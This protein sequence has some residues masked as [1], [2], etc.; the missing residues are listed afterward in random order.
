M[1]KKAINLEILTTYK[2]NKNCP[3]CLYGQEKDN[4]N[5]VSLGWLEETLNYIARSFDIKSICLS[6]GEISLLGDFYLE[7]LF[8]L[9]KLYT[10][11][12]RV[13]TNLKLLNKTILN[14]FDT[15]DVTLNFNSFDSEIDSSLENI[16][17]ISNSKILNIKSLDRSCEDNPTEIIDLLNSLKIKSWE[18][19]PYH[20]TQ[21]LPYKV[22]D[23]HKYENIVKQYLNLYKEMNFAFQNRQQLQNIYK[24]DNYNIQNFYITPNNKIAIQTFDNTNNFLLKEVEDITEISKIFENNEKIRD[25]FCSKCTSKLKC[26]ANYFFNPAYKGNSCSG[27]K[28]LIEYYNK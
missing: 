15:L 22:N 23:Y 4:Q 21:Y 2:C 5:N 8:R 27:A 26:L 24:K 1:I 17:K 16:R 28:D 25:N 20:H 9:C 3:F 18:I 12:I 7:L 19:I 6:G 13:C 14:N 11:Q 10:K